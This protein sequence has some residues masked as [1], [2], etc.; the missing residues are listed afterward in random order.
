MHE[1]VPQ[2]KRMLVAYKKDNPIVPIQLETLR[3][4]MEAEGVTMVEIPALTVAD[5]ETALKE[6]AKSPGN[7]VD[8]ILMIAE[9]LNVSPAGFLLLAKFA[10][11]HKIPIGGASMSAG[12]YNSIFGVATDNIAVGK[13]SALLADKIL[14]GAQTGS[15]PVVSA[16]NFL[17]INY[18]AA[19]ELGL[20]VS[21]ELLGQANQVIR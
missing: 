3:P 14:K 15:I 19:Q 11:E 1:L 17:Q 2:A 8:A 16:E 6:M 5:I 20:Q 21:D 9:P 12:G 4:K 7:D 13:Q 18:K 10:A